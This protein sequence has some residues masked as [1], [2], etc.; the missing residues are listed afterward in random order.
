[1]KKTLMMMAM[2]MMAMMVGA[3]GVYTKAVSRQ[4]TKAAKKWVKKG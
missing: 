4:E 3:Q 2:M 1:M